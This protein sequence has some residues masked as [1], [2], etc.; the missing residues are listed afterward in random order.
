[1]KRRQ[2]LQSI[3]AIPAVVAAMDEISAHDAPS[4]VVTHPNPDPV[5]HLP[6]DTTLVDR[7]TQM[8]MHRI[9]V[10]YSDGTK[11]IFWVRCS[12]TVINPHT[13]ESEYRPIL[14]SITSYR[15]S[16]IVDLTDNRTLKTRFPEKRVSAD[17]FINAPVVDRPKYK[18]VVAT[19]PRM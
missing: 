10:E 4:A 12:G 1:M 13:F 7:A 16:L 2:F 17:H 15:A 8:P 9:G 3:V 14:D 11:E 6:A 19:G 5:G 18:H